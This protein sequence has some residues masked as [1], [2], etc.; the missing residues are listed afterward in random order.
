MTNKMVFKQHTPNWRFHLRIA[1]CSITL[2]GEC[3]CRAWVSTM[4]FYCASRM[5]S[6][7]F[8]VYVWSVGVHVCVWFSSALVRISRQFPSAATEQTE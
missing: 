5:L 4:P 6:C 1:H 3:K 8:P 2:S 7:I